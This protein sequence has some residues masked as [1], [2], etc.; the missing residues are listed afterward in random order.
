VIGSLFLLL[1]LAPAI[2]LE[3]ISAGS[4]F[5]TAES[6]P[7]P[8]GLLLSGLAQTL[9]LPPVVLYLLF[10]YEGAKNTRA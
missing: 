1:F 10:L 3:S 4:V 6:F 2:A 5:S 7:R 9:T 8:A